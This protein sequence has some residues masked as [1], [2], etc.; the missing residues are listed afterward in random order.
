MALAV[1]ANANLTPTVIQTPVEDDYNRTLVRFALDKNGEEHVVLWQMLSDTQCSYSILA[2]DGSGNSIAS[3]VAP[4][5][6]ALGD[7]ETQH[8]VYGG[9]IFTQNLFND[10][11]NWEYIVEERDASYYCTSTV[12]NDKNEC[13]GSYEGQIIQIVSCGSTIFATFYISRTNSD[14]LVSF[15]GAPQS[16]ID[17]VALRQACEV[18]AYPNPLPAGATLTIDLG[19]ELEADGKVSIISTSGRQVYGARVRA[20]ESSLQIPS[21]RLPKGTYIYIVES[22]GQ[23]I[24]SD[25]IIID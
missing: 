25:R 7:P 4:N 13:L 1:S 3:F 6:N 17:N 19:T 12:F 9:F 10:D 22:R 20:N 8:D 24:A 11:D 16:R 5:P 23:L 18:T 21:V 15:K 2:N 14:I